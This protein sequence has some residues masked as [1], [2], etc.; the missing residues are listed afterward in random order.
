MFLPS[1]MGQG[2]T[3]QQEYWITRSW[4][5]DVIG[6]YAQVRYKIMK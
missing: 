4:N 6:T 3:K 1:I 2:T 5:G